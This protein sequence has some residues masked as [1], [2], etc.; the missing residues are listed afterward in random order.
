MWCIMDLILDTVTMIMTLMKSFLS[1]QI[2][3]CESSPC[4]HGQC[5]DHVDSYICDCNPGYQGI[6]CD[7]RANINLIR[8]KHY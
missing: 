2:N 8:N 1:E 5:T 4:A 3:E 6:N 7:G